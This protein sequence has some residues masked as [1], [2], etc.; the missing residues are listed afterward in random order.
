[1]ELL[2]LFPTLTELAGLPSAAEAPGQE[3][4][5]APEG[6]GKQDPDFAF[7][8]HPRPAYYDR[9]EKGVPDA[10]GYSI[11]T[12]KVRYTEWRDW[13]TGNVIAA[14]LY[15]HDRDP[16]ELINRFDNPTDQQPLAEAKELL[17][18]AVPP[19]VPPSNR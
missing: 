19:D 10:M 18:K 14:E 13:E 1:M 11:R 3:P 5:A 15:E 17:W 7:S 16:H 6:P 2:D 8:Q 12:D 9:T 4:R